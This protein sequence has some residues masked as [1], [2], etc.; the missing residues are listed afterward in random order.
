MIGF[1][2]CKPGN[3]IANLFISP[4]PLP[5]I[6]VRPNI[7]LCMPFLSRPLF[8]IYRQSTPRCHSPSAVRMI[9]NLF[10]LRTCFAQ[11]SA[12]ALDRNYSTSKVISECLHD[13]RYKSCRSLCSIH[14]HNIRFTEF[15]KF[16]FVK[17]DI[18]RLKA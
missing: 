5:E 17:N 14:S 4:P 18:L 7:P 11:H 15:R 10:Y 16:L 3:S 12:L 9:R 8:D 6:P 13:I 1:F 2:N